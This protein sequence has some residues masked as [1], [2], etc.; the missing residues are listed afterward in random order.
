MLTEEEDKKFIKNVRWEMHW[1]SIDGPGEGHWYEISLSDVWKE[2]CRRRSD[3]DR[4]EVITQVY[5]LPR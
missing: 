5:T 1:A 3:L 4:K 2:V